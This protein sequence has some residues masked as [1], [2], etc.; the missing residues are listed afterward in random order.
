MSFEETKHLIIH[1][2]VNMFMCMWNT[3]I[4][5]KIITSKLECS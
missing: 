4:G 5:L 1:N 2:G 3:E